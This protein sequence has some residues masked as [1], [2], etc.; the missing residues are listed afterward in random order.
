M[1]GG[2]D[3]VAPAHV[4][5]ETRA[6]AADATGSMRLIDNPVD[7]IFSH[8]TG[9][10]RRALAAFSAGGFSLETGG[11]SSLDGDDDAVL[12]RIV[13]LGGCAS[14]HPTKTVPGW[15]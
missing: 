15:I 8:E 12:G 10:L 4:I 2:Q 3:A 13:A 5:N 9:N 1:D 7:P 11:E 6:G 14:R